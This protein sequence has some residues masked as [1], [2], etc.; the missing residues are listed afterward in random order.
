MIRLIYSFLSVNDAE[1]DIPLLPVRIT[2]E[3]MVVIY[4]GASL[5]T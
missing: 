3:A 4:K 5:M 1:T 2:A